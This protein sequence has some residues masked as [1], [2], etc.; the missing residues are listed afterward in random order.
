MKKNNSSKNSR[1]INIDIVTNKS[2]KLRLSIGLIISACIIYGAVST[3][4]SYATDVHKVIRAKKQIRKEYRKTEHYAEDPPEDPIYVAIVDNGF[5]MDHVA[6]YHNVSTKYVYSTDGSSDIREVPQ[7]SAGEYGLTHHGTHVVGILC[8]QMGLR[9][10]GTYG[11]EGVAPNAKVILVQML[12]NSSISEMVQ[13]FNYI[14]Q[15]PAKIVSMSMSFGG[16]LKDGS[17]TADSSSYS[18]TGMP[19]EIFEAIL[20]LANR[21]KIIVISAGNNGSAL[22]SS[23]YGWSLIQ[24]AQLAKG[25]VIIAGASEYRD[26]NGVLSYLF[27]KIFKKWSI[28][29]YGDKMAYFSNYPRTILGA[30]HFITA[31][32]VNI[33][34]SVTNMIFPIQTMSGTSMSAP[35]VAGALVRIL[36]HLPS[37]NAD[38]A[39]KILFD[40]ARKNNLITGALLS[41]DFGAGIVDLSILDK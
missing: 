15:T 10:N 21:G 12:P 31:P 5:D 35:I 23:P 27:S 39:V 3:F 37:K 11:Y 36:E 26:N 1:K 18:N 29:Y 40:S 9:A 4:F 34:S 25:R 41:S 19:P 32:G 22:E 2:N 6:Y 13:A 20:Q 38:E 14:Q 33:E 30:S 7:Y 24:L 17:G 16:R 8:G 28:G